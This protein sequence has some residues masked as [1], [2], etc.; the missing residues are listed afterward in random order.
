MIAKCAA[1]VELR[2]TTEREVRIRQRYFQI[3]ISY[4]AAGLTELLKV[5][6][7]DVIAALLKDTHDDVS[8]AL[9]N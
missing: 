5:N 4:S 2:S 7:L 8:C 6:D 1:N 3:S 9:R